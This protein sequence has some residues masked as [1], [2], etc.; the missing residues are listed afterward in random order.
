MA[1]SVVRDRPETVLR[2]EEHL[3]F[4]RV[5]IQRPAVRERHGGALAPVLVVDLCAV[6]GRDRAAG[7]FADERAHGYPPVGLV[8]EAQAFTC[9][10]V[11][12]RLRSARLAQGMPA[13][14]LPA[15]THGR[16]VFSM[17]LG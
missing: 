15:G 6:L 1:P 8:A 9:L 10:I 14:F 3:G 12:T 17:K 5:G 11:A 13:T 7:A 4:P 16:S 2:E